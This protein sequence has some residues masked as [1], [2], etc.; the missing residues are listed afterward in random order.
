M[1]LSAQEDH[2]C[3][4]RLPDS[5]CEEVWQNQ[6]KGRLEQ[7]GVLPVPADLSP[8]VTHSSAAAASG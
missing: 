7:P 5:S 2:R 8:V 1:G 4:S 3:W 6:G